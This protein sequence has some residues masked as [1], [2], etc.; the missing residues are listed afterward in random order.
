MTRPGKVDSCCR[1][2]Q[3]LTGVE[4]LEECRVTFDAC[5]ECCRT[6]LPTPDSLNPVVASLLHALAERIMEQAGVAGCSPAAALHW[7]EVAEEHLYV[8]GVAAS[9]PVPLLPRSSEGSLRIGLLGLHTASG[10]GSLNRDLATQ[11]AIE[12]W[13]VVEDPSRPTLP[14][15]ATIQQS[16]ATPSELAG[17]WAEFVADLDWVLFCERPFDWGLPGLA[18]RTGTR[19]ACIPMWEWLSP[20]LPWLRDVDLMLCPT[21]ACFRLLRS[22]RARFGFRWEL[23]YVRWP[24][25]LNRFQFRQRTVCR[26]FLFVDGMGGAAAAVPGQSEG[27]PGRKGADVIAA[28]AAL[29]PHVSI[30]VRTQRRRFPRMPAN[31]EVLPETDEPSQL[32]EAGDVCVQPSY[33]EGLGLQLLES[34]ACGLPLVT[35]DAAPMNEASPY[36]R[37]PCRA[38][39]VE[40]AGRRWWAHRSDPAE[41]ARTLASL[42]QQEVSQASLAAR[43]QIERRHG[44]PSALRSIRGALAR[45]AGLPGSTTG[46]R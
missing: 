24:V 30:V 1:L 3:N 17:I 12:R 10:L 41:L 11:L 22:W 9:N 4:D 44:W 32:Y 26:R 33:W 23:Q 5:R 21:R 43:R 18:R 25:D 15:L 45:C 16:T 7:R 2:L 42:D 35:T 34:Q 37:L 38:Q 6:F 31:V 40:L 28:A 46:S 27:I 29:A 14:P 19:V 20:E 36:R 8:E 39:R 13:L